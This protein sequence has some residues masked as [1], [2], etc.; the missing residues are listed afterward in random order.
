MHLA[1]H[2]H[3]VAAWL[4]GADQ[5]RRVV[6]S[7]GTTEAVLALAAPHHPIDRERAGGEGISVTRAVDGVHEGVL[8]GDPAAGALIAQWR[9][10]VR[11]AGAD[12]EVLLGLAPRH[13]GDAL[14]LPYPRGRQSPTPDPLARYELLDA[15]PSDPAAELTGI[16]RG[17]AAHGAWM[18]EVVADLVGAGPQPEVAAIG[19]PVR[20]NHRLAGLMASLAG[21]PIQVVDLAAPVASGAALLAAERAGLAARVH[22]PTRMVAPRDDGAPDLAARF[23]AAVAASTT[24][25]PEGA[26]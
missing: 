7:L 3:A 9:E 15:D 11:G 24:T 21:G 22:P 13:P 10:R 17:L 14:A 23:A 20:A 6:H 18:R 4:A 1:G 8:A 12:P 16:L 25:V 5:P 2:D 19:T 26:A